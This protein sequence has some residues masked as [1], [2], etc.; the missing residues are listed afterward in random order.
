M[1]AHLV[2]LTLLSV[3]TAL[4]AP[5]SAQQPFKMLGP[6]ECLNCHDH[7]AEREWYEK[8][9]IPEVRRLFPEKGANA[10]HINSLNQMEADKSNEYAKA[11]GL[12]DKYD[13][14]GKCVS[15]HATVFRGDANAGVSCESCHG[16]GSGYLKPHQTK[17]SYEQS[18]AQFGMTKLIGNIAGWTQQCT[19]CHVMDDARLIKAGHPSGDDFDLTRKYAPVSLHFKKKY[20]EADIAPT[21]RAQMEGIIRFRRGETGPVTA[22]PATAPAAPSPPPPPPTANPG[23]A[24]PP[25][26][27]VPTAPAAAPAAPSRP[28]ATAPAAEPARPI[29]PAAPPPGSPTSIEPRFPMV[30][31]AIPAAPAPAPAPAPAAA[32]PAPTV[33]PSSAADPAE[34]WSIGLLPIVVVAVV[35][36]LAFLWW[37]RRRKSA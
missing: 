35:V 8:K 25:A 26:V 30:L 15:C 11:I 23:S 7:D 27:L 22:A 2:S 1:R 29:D 4:A 28:R 3:F 19:N 34:S 32:A 31:P 20:A 5:A 6:N 12:A 18:V 24:A 10:G 36:P 37:R 16:P 21:A 14:N 9:E 33:V 17:D 13:V